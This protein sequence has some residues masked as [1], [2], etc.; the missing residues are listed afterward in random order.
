MYI[1]LVLNKE[2]IM[3]ENKYFKSAEKRDKWIEKN[4]DKYVIDIIFI[5]NGY[6]VEYKK[7]RRIM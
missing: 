1:N 4:K 6:G 5:N 7:I 3:W 2:L